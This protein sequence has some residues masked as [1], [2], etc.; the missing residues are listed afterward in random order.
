[1]DQSIERTDPTGES[2]AE[3]VR[4]LRKHDQQLSAFVHAAVPGWQDAEDVLQETSVRLWEQFDNYRPGSNFGAWAC[5]VARY[6]VMAG[7]ERQKRDKLRFTAETLEH[8]AAEVD[9][10]AEVTIERREKLALCIEDLSESNRQ[11]LALSYAKG[12]RVKEVA[13]QLDR[14]ANAT[15]LAL[16]R[17]RRWLHDCV[18]RRLQREA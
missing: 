7:W 15:Y 3:F 18:G 12:M 1:M 8:I 17:V 6:M 2:T 4:L 14:T 10:V 13:A 11:L 5:T 16:S 9:R